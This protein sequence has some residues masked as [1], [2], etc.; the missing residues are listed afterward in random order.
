MD[1]NIFTAIGALLIAGFVG[2]LTG[3]F[4][5]GGGFLMTPA[6]IIILGV[7]A[8]IAVGTDLLT[9]FVTS[10][11][12][13]FRRRGSKT[14]DPKLAGVIAIGSL[15]GVFIGISIMELLKG[16]EPLRILG[17]E[18]NTVQYLLLCAFLL[19]LGWIAWYLYFDYHRNQGLAPA[20]RVG[21]FAKLK[22]WPYADFASL[23][24]PRLSI[25]PLIAVGLLVGTLTGLMGVGGGI[26]M[27]PA[28]VYW[29]GLRT[30]KA[31]GTSLIIVWAS[32]MIAA[33]A[34]L[35][36]GNVDFLLWAL[37][38]AGGLTG[39]FYGTKIGLKFPGPKLRLYFVYVI[40]A[41]VAMVGWKL[42]AI[43]F[44]QGQIGQH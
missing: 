15:V 31:V 11:F 10:S 33:S 18:H 9:I 20:K 28:L 43:T 39:T 23:E 12:G 26:V 29:V 41:A 42:L 37:L 32:S 38:L 5:V 7:D 21:L 13:I 4:G 14:I 44:L 3:I 17:K 1:I 16:M 35:Y 25:V 40:L 34:H 36:N 2:M 6:L 30:V 24:E 27:L 22:L 19:L 8:H